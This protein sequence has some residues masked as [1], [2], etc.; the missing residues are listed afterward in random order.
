M[1][2]QVTDTRSIVA[3]LRRRGRLLVAAALVGFALGIG[4]VLALPP[5]VTSTTLVLLPTPA[6]SEVSNSDVETQVRIALSA[7]ILERAGQAVAPPLSARSV[8]KMAQRFGTDEPGHPDRNDV[9]ISHRLR[10]SLGFS[11]VPRRRFDLDDL[12]RR[13]RNVAIFFTERAERGGAT[14]CPARSR[15]D[16]LSAMRT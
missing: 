6:V 12:V 1:I 9:R 10:E 5:P 8:K 3:T 11:R 15:M 4:Y 2:N 13:C 14:A 7:S 16:A